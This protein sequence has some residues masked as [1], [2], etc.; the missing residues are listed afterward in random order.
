MICEKKKHFTL[1]NIAYLNI[2]K[3]KVKICALKC[4][5]SLKML[6]FFMVTPNDI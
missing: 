5:Q 6:H 2:F 1:E 3:K 4:F